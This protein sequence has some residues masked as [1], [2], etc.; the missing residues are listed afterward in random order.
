M[1][2]MKK[3]TL[4]LSLI[5]VVA[6]TGVCNANNLITLYIPASLSQA[7][8]FPVKMW[9]DKVVIA[10][11]KEVMKGW[12]TTCIGASFVDKEPKPKLPLIKVQAPPPLP[13]VVKLVVQPAPL[14]K[15]VVQPVPVPPV[16]VEKPKPELDSVPF[17]INKT[18][19]NPFAAKVLDKNAV[20]IKEYPKMKIE[21]HGHTDNTGSE[22]ANKIISEK[23]AKSCEK[24]LMDKFN[25]ADERMDIKGFGSSRPITDNSTI[26]GRAKN[27]KARQSLIL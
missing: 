15:P 14:V 25:I 12:H 10:S 3:V 23:R 16:V 27:R 26:E 4:L 21:I 24:Y 9:N 20:I 8:G 2:I 13:P 5:L 18:N 7:Y 17:D 11:T 6:F 1:K 19:I 22:V